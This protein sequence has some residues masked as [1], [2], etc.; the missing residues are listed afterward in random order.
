[1]MSCLSEDISVHESKVPIKD[2]M[3]TDIWFCTIIT[4]GVATTEMVA[5]HYLIEIKLG[6][7]WLTAAVPSGVAW[8]CILS[9]FVTMWVCLIICRAL[10][11]VSLCGLA[12]HPVHKSSKLWCDVRL[13]LWRAAMVSNSSCTDIF[14]WCFLATFQLWHFV[15]V[16]SSVKSAV[17]N[18][19]NVFPS[20]SL[21]IS[22][23]V[24]DVHT[25]GCIFPNES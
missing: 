5:G 14:K 7:C 17:C 12:A 11:T 19:S 3:L 13:G 20:L 10:P 18:S 6:W 8:P 2:E 25:F 22:Y 4:Y 9:N 15:M 16:V 24:P 21:S 23:L 1:M